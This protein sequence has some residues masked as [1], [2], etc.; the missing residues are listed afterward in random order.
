MQNK[1]EMNKLKELNEYVIKEIDARLDSFFTEKVAKA[2]NID[3]IYEKLL[4]DMKKFIQRGGKRLRPTLMLLGYKSAGGTEFTTALDASLSLEI[5]HNF[6]LIHDDVMDGD[7]TRYGGAN[8]TGIYYKRF[9]KQLPESSAKHTA[10]SIAI[11]AGELN[12][13][14]TFEVL[15]KLDMKKETIFEM[16]EHFQKVLFETGAGQQ[17]DVMSSIRG[18]LNLNKIEKVNYYKTA[19]YTV[20]S[21]LQLGVIAAG[22]ND[23]LMKDF[24]KFGAEL[25]KAFQI[26]D[27]LLGM[28]GSTRQT[29][30]PVG[31][32]IREGKQTLLM[33]YAKKLAK[34]LEW[35]GIQS[36]L[37][38]EDITAEDVKLVRN[39]L[40]DC[41]AQAK[42]VVAAEDHLQRALKIISNMNIDEDT[43]AM[44]VAF[45]HYCVVR[46]K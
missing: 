34:P 4:F 43:K 2:K 9:K 29:G 30:K 38:K 13:F 26:A 19:Q 27:D 40:K 46:K 45:S 10:E 11:L 39:I 33:Y 21:P 23:K 12:E 22:G 28:F 17:L 24:S 7:M 1:V 14:F 37:G 44:L 18:D 8:M 42:A 6:V 3:P 15:T 31:S 16:M 41:G 25:G 35:K 5:F 20:T 32:D 36:R